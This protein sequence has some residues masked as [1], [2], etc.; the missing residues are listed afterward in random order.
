MVCASIGQMVG[1][2]RAGAAK[3]NGAQSDDYNIT[4]RR[5]TTNGRRVYRIDAYKPGDI[6]ARYWIAID[7]N[8]ENNECT[9]EF[10]K[11]NKVVHG[12]NTICKHHLAVKQREEEYYLPEVIPACSETAT[13]RVWCEWCEKYLTGDEAAKAATTIQSVNAPGEYEN[14]TIYQCESCQE[15]QEC[16]GATTFYY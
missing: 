3:I 11:E 15:A 2:A 4:Y 8:D 14:F 16:E 1:M 6:I 13:P 5:T 7:D 10:Y 12:A 9:C